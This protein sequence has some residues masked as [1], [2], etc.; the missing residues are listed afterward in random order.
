MIIL[1]DPA[2]LLHDTVELLGSKLVPAYESPARV[3]A[4]L[5]S[6]SNSH[7]SLEHVRL[8]SRDDDKQSLLE[9]IADS[10]GSEYLA[11]LRDS[12]LQWREKDLVEENGSILPE[13]FPV[14]NKANSANRPPK[15]I[16]ARTGYF[17]FDMSSG[18]MKD[19]YKSILASANLARSA[20][21]RLRSDDLSAIVAL[22]RPPGHHCNG[23]KAGGYCYVNNVAVAASQ[24]R[25]HAPGA[26]IGI[27]DIDFH[28]GN[29]TQD[30]FYADSNTFYTSIHGEDEFPYYTGNADEEGVDEGLGANLNI[31]LRPGSS[32]EAYLEF[33][34]LAIDAL[35][36]FAPEMLI[37]SLGFDT[38]RLDPLGSFQIDTAD[39][40][41]IGRSIRERLGN[42]P[43]AILLEG[44]YVVEHLGANLLSFIRGWEAGR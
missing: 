22:T 16:F 4:I 11:H 25:K 29:G 43:T 5:E 36:V 1:H 28:H 13:C 23:R 40:E 24:W 39:Y 18:I 41:T 44:G 37:V 31:P 30:I 19:S 6:I 15:D 7:H 21:E 26:K 27:L 3:R 12:F 20:V 42:I 8:E 9:I 35:G 33:L 32:V 2:T 10:H 34:R 38:F 14:A 17:A